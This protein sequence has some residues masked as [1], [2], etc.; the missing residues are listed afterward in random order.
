M[1]YRLFETHDT[2][3]HAV[4][5]ANCSDQ[6]AAEKWARDWVSAN[7]RCDEYTIGREDGA[8]SSLFKTTSGQWYV[9]RN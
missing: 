3:A 1:D 8:S 4:A 5:T 9:M 7:G 2:A 6:F